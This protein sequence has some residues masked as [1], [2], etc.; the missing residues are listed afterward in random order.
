MTKSSFKK[1]IVVHHPS[2]VKFFFYVTKVKRIQFKKTEIIFIFGYLSCKTKR[3]IGISVGVFCQ[4]GIRLYEHKIVEVNA[5]IFVE[6]CSSAKY[7]WKLFS[8]NLK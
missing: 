1:T 8:S 3:L 5:Y 2:V 6:K 4:G 7:A